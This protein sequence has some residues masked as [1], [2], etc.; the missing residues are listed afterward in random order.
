MKETT[1]TKQ[2]MKLDDV[3]FT[4]EQFEK[5][6]DIC[7]TILF[8]PTQECRYY[9]CQHISAGLRKRFVNVFIISE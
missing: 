3:Y 5:E 1:T 2:I 4:M 9:V 7:L 8:Y 6:L